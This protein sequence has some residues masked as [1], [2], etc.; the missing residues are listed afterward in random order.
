MAQGSVHE[1]A[2]A[3]ELAL[4]PERTEQAQAGI[5]GCGSVKN[6]ATHLARTCMEILHVV[7]SKVAMELSMGMQPCPIQHLEG[8]TGEA[9]HLA[10]LLKVC[11]GLSNSHGHDANAH[12]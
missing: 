7:L 6:M 8:R 9:E 12:G 4:A 11:L 3:G 2:V 10:L 5:P 1:A